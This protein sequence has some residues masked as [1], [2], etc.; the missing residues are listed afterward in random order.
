MT[1]GIFQGGGADDWGGRASSQP[2]GS[3]RPCHRACG[4]HLTLE[5]VRASPKKRALPLG[6]VTVPPGWS[7]GTQTPAWWPGAP[8][9]RQGGGRAGGGGPRAA[10]PGG[11]QRAGMAKGKGVCL[12]VKKKECGEERSFVLLERQARNTFRR[13]AVCHVF[14]LEIFPST[15]SLQYLGK[16]TKGLFASLEGQCE[17]GRKP[18]GC[19][20]QRGGAA[21]QAPPPGIPPLPPQHPA[22]GSSGSHL[23][24][25]QPVSLVLLC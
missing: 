11:G 3:P 25:G 21:V 18:G 5:G 8:R 19:G 2:C 20:L 24:S 6:G 10:G 23:G 14:L 12:R 7:P 1:P 15:S 13:P 9:Q 16:S 17:P 4:E 22:L